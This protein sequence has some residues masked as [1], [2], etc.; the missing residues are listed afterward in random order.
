MPKTT[1]KPDLGACE[2]MLGYRF[3]NRK[4]LS[5]ALTHRSFIHESGGPLG[6]DNDRLE[7][8]GD[9]VLGLVVAEVAYRRWPNHNEGE[10]TQ[11]KSQV[12]S[13]KALARK[14]AQMKLADFMRLGKGQMRTGKPPETILSCGIEA[15]IG[16]IYMD[17]GLEKAARFIHRQVW[18]QNTH[19][20]RPHSET[21]NYKEKLQTLYLKHHRELPA[22]DCLEESGPAHRRR[23]VMAVRL[24]GK[25][26]AKG[27]GMSKKEASQQAAR[28]AL[29]RIRSR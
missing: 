18:A 29:K 26:I 25:L 9:S 3:R 2:R 19:K 14:G 16:A 4:L 20:P 11:A 7:F 27:E 1:M 15:L 6:P 8:L 22:Y 24:K 12:V 13:R 28:L 23:F 17:G 21:Q 5:L 10:L